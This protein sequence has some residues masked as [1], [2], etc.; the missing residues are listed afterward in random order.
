M[1]GPGRRFKKGQSGNPKGAP[2][3][4]YDIKLIKLLTW[5]DLALACT[6]LVF[7]NEPECTRIDM[8]PEEPMLKKIIAKALLKAWADGNFSMLNQILDRVVGKV[9][10]VEPDVDEQSRN[11]Q[12][13][14]EMIRKVIDDPR[15]ERTA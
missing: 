1:P 2:K 14:L 3:P 13:V 12:A 15:N 8:D 4:E 11:G 10:E 5:K 6:V 9:R 7:A